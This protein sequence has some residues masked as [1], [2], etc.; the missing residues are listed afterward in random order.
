MKRLIKAEFSKLITTRMTYGL[1]LGAAAAAVLPVVIGILRS[2]QNGVPSLGTVSNL[3]RIISNSGGMATIFAQVLGI[4]AVAGEFR[5]KTAGTTF[6][7][8]PRRSRVILAK[9]ISYP[10]F[11]LL[12]GVVSIAAGLS[13]SMFWLSMSGIDVGSVWN[14]PVA[15]VAA[16][17]VLGAGLYCLIGVGL[18]ALF[19][20]QLAAIIVA[21]A[22]PQVIENI[23]HD[24]TWLYRWA[25][26]GANSALV[27]ADIAG[28]LPAWG[29]GLLL[30]AYGLVFGLLGSLLV[31]SRDIS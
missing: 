10:V 11:G 5:H 22:W 4:T 28:L 12:I 18:G 3:R 16:S 19:R 1:I 23:I 26:G 14:A 20:N 13:I 29:G 31:A 6:L 8:S 27:R 21:L 24:M 30:L 17:W 7:A 2:G 15:G 25:P 9:A